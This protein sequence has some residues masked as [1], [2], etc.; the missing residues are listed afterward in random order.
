M[1][2]YI[3]YS[4]YKTRY[5]KEVVTIKKK[6]LSKGV[7]GSVYIFVFSFTYVG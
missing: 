1:K 4:I 7:N 6:F 5:S 3:I 2:E